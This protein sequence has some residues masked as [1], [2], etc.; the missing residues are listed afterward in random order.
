MFKKKIIILFGFLVFLTLT[1]NSWAVPAQINFQ[2][3][4]EDSNGPVDSTLNITFR[5]FGSDVN[6][7]P[8]WEEEQSVLVI[9][10]IYNVALGTGT[11]NPSYDSLEAALL[12]TD[13]L[14][15][16]VHIEDEPEPMSPR[17]K[18]TSVGFAIRSGMA[19]TVPDGTITTDKLAIGAVD[20]ARLA[21]GA[22]TAAKVT[23]GPDSGLN[24]D[25]L[26]GKS[27]EYFGT[28]S[29]LEQAQDDIT[30]LQAE[31]QALK[32]LLAGVT[33]SV[34]NKN[35]YFTGMNV[36]VRSGEG[37]TD[38][39]VNGLGNLIV[40][41][42]ESRS[43]SN[44]R[45]G[46]HNIVVGSKQNYSSYGGFVAGYNNT[47][48]GDYSSVS[49]GGSNT[50]GGDYSSVSG[51]AGNFTTGTYAS[52]SGGQLNKA[53]HTS[54]SVSGG[55][56]NTASGIQSSVNGGESNVASG[57]FSSVSGGAR[58]SASG[59]RSSIT[60]GYD[61]TAFGYGSSATGGQSNEA[62]GTYSH[63]SGG[64]NNK[65]HHT[66]SQIAAAE[67]RNTEADYEFEAQGVE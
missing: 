35:L 59:E 4:L 10:G 33:R 1:S 21:D 50:A 8:L 41:Y 26:D 28:A 53:E 44:N 19:E 16:E 23:D 30:A 29:A 63:V 47:I 6:G 48:S 22:V 64:R 51:G 40:G 5:L 58:N 17:Q 42:N 60:A 39:T 2:G 45:T 34:D 32:T 9:Q 65:A 3:M 7:T 12:S 46:S 61:N 49:G 24:A 57:K 38:A 36:H 62:I 31:V 25:E 43:Y 11:L 20:T 13:Q 54:S 27:A 56:N 14:W 52:I 37:A 15:L 66:G 55:L 67:N 18:I